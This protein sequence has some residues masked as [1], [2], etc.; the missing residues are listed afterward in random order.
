MELGRRDEEITTVIDTAD[1]VDLRRAAM[2]EHRSQ[3][4][5]FDGL[6]DALGWAFLSEAQLVRVEPAWSGGAVETILWS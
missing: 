5:P 1:V 6:S 4:S 3:V 2:A